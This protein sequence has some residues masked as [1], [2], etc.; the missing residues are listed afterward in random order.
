M[1][2]VINNSIE[3]GVF[4]KQY[5]GYYQFL[6]DS[7]EIIVFEEV[8]PPVLK[9]FDLKSSEYVGKSFLIT[10]SEIM[11]NNDEDFIIYRIEKLE[12]A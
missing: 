1:K 6:M 12:F 3:Y 2:D 9:K 4:K 5:N 7:G 8:Y 10:Y 11:E